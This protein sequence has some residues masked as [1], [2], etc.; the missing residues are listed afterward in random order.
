MR[1][2]LDIDESVLA[3]INEIALRKKRSTDAVASDLLRF[4]LANST[5][6]EDHG[7]ATSC[8]FVPFVAGPSD[9]PVPNEYVDR[10][11]EELGI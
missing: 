9:L 2:T 8:G 6:H 10:I 4:A 5:R 7:P 3:A 1:I 11:R